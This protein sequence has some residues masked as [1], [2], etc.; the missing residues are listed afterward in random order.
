MV[1]PKEYIARELH[2]FVEA[3]E[4]ARVRYLYDAGAGIHFV[5]ALPGSLY[6]ADAYTA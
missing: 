5:E 2:G 1:T 6:G 3:F 4:N